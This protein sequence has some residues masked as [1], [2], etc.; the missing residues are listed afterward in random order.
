MRRGKLT[1][2]S[3]IFVILAGFFV[4]ISFFLD[5]QVIQKEDDLRNIAIKI[6]NKTEKINDLETNS[7][8]V[9]LLEDRAQMLTNYYSFFSTIFY[10]IYLNLEE[11]VDFKKHFNNYGRKTFIDFI[12]HDLNYI[13]YDL[14]AIRADTTK[15]SFYWHDYQ[16]KELQDKVKS[17]FLHDHNAMKEKYYEK[18]L[19]ASKLDNLGDIEFSS[20]EIHEIY[21]TLFQLNKEFALSIVKLNDINNYFDEIAENE[22]NLLDLFL[23][24]QIKIKILKN[25]F[26]LGS[27]SFQI[28]SLLALL[29]LFRNIIKES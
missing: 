28:L 12:T 10:K 25:Y 7:T 2:S 4:L 17:L 9:L 14:E 26:I 16:N 20:N 23:Q 13:Y 21:K 22:T 1:K 27:I 11:D 5:Q 8:T 3:V 19:N 29:F 6:T 24:N 18:I 15:M